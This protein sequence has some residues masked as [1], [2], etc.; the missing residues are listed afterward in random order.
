M[1]KSPLNEPVLS[2]IIPLYREGFLL[3][4]VLSTIQRNLEFLNESYE[5]I[6]VD[7][8]SPDDT[9]AVIEEQ[10]KNYPMLR[11][12]RLSRN[13]G[14]ESALCAGLDMARGSAV[15]VIDGDLQHP[16]E[17]IPEMVRLWKEEKFQVV[18]GMKAS[19]GKEPFS[20]RFGAKFFYWITDHLTGFPL[21]ASSD[22]KLLDRSVVEALKTMG[23]RS[24]LFRG[25]VT[26]LGFRRT[27]IPFSVADR[28][29]GRSHWSRRK[30]LRLAVNTITSFSSLPLHLV[31]LMGV[32]TLCFSVLMALHTLYIKWS[33][34]AVSGFATVIL[35]LL[36]M[37]G[38][39]MISLG[40]IG[41]YMARIYEEVKKRPLYI[42]EKRLEPDLS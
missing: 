39:L 16:P 30:L 21:H 13:F 8:G 28:L 26:W 27:T 19:R 25:M 41:E 42:I 40:I 33:G 9:W 37:N 34:Q 3:K 1:N 23:E 18:E 38:V 15:I 31:T 17:L 20:Y 2:V 29:S 5:L 32:F 35:L 12:L 14:K 10:S 4:T 36:L 6:L 22:Y 11:A 24:R 7:D